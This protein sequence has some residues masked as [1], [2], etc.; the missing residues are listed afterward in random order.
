MNVWVPAADVERLTELGLEPK[1]FAQAAVKQALDE[2]DQHQ[3][4]ALADTLAPSPFLDLPPLTDEENQL[5]EELAVPGSTRTSHDRA[6]G[7][8]DE[9]LETVGPEGDD[10]LARLVHAPAPNESHASPRPASSAR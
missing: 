7:S 6:P 2:L 9:L 8:T 10:W 3:A 5:L 4:E 1:E